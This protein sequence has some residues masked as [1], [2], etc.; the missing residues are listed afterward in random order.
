MPVNDSMYIRKVWKCSIEEELI[1]S[2]SSLIWNMY[3]QGSIELLAKPGIEFKKHGE[4]GM[5]I[6]YYWRAVDQLRFRFA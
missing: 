1:L 5:A 3:A 4:Y 2:T 6:E